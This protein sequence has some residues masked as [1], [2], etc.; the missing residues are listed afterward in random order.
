M[1]I[2]ERALEATWNS[3]MAGDEV[4]KGALRKAL[5]AYESTRTPSPNADAQLRASAIAILLGAEPSESPGRSTVED[6][7]LK[8]LGEAVQSASPPP[9]SGG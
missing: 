3:L 1:T 6:W 9:S 5:E 7:R 8:A 4:G 2:D